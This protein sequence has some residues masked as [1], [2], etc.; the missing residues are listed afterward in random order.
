MAMGMDG[1][2]MMG[3]ES[4]PIVSPWFFILVKIQKTLTLHIPATTEVV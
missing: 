4:G 2:I 3:S 1:R